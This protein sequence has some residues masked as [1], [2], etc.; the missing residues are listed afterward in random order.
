MAASMNKVFLMGNLGSDPEL[1]YTPKGD[2]V[3]NFSIA[4][5]SVYNEQDRTDWFRVTAWGKVAESCAQYL[6]KGSKVFVEGRLRENKW[7][8]N[9]GNERRTVE[10]TASNVQF[11]D[12][13]PVQNEGAKVD[14]DDIPF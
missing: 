12:P 3:A 1:R 6:T 10:V 7:E 5:N 13:K 14:E 2:P 11:L 9:E 8:D 4:I